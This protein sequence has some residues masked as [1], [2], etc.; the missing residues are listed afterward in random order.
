M[1]ELLLERLNLGSTDSLIKKPEHFKFWSNAKKL[2]WLLS[3]LEPSVD[4]L[5][6]VYEAQSVV[7][8]QSDQ[9]DEL[10]NYSL[11]YLRTMM[12]F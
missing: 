2:D 5:Y 6:R 11:S 4:E 10:Y 8:L 3:L 12:G 9:G 7:Q 1:V